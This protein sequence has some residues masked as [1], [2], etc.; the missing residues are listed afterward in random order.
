[1]VVAAVFFDLGDVLI[2]TR[3]RAAMRALAARSPY[4]EGGVR[5]KLRELKRSYELGEL[6]SRE[7]FGDAAATLALPPEL[8]FEDFRAMWNRW[9]GL[10][11]PGT[12]AIVEQLKFPL[13]LLSNTNEMHHQQCRSLLPLDRLFRRQFVSYRLGTAKPELDIYAK[14]LRLANKR[15][16][17]CLFIDDLRR[18]VAGARAAGMDAV[19]FRSAG[20]LS[21]ELRKRGIL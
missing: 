3:E 10:P 14:A 13:Y 11:V 15:A 19:R 4:G 7:F 20:Q 6:G 8:S 9:I 17:D 12:L 21:G 2:R 1:M 16:E 5:L 18:N